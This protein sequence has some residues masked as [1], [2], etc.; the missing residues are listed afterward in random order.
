MERYEEQSAQIERIASI[1][2]G[3]QTMLRERNSSLSERNKRHLRQLQKI[4]RISDHYQKMLHDLNEMLKVSAMQDPLT[5]LPNRR[6]MTDRLNVEVQMAPRRF[7]PFSVILLDIDHFKTINDSFGHA[8]GDQALSAVAHILTA[9][10]RDYDMAAR[11]GGEEFLL[12]LPETKARDAR[13]IAQ[14]IRTAIEACAV[15]DAP[16][17]LRL[18]ASFG[19]TQHELASDCNS[20]VARADIAL[21]QAKNGGRNRVVLFDSELAS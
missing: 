1:S 2:D 7:A 16:A 13:D 8:V 19:V 15:P 4:V 14:R 10:L 20:T 6:L 11:W 9:N 18:T 3:F 21:Y 5:E 17:A 12:L